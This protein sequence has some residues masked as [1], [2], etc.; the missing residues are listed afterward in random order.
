VAVRVFD[1][2]LP[3]ERERGL[4]A[5]AQSIAAAA[6]VVVPTDTVYGLC[7]DAFSAAAVTSLV[8]AKGTGAAPPVLV[9]SPDALDGLAMEVSSAARSLVEGFWPGGLTLLCRARP[10]LD[11]GLGDGGTVAIRMPLHPLSLELLERTGPLAASGANVA[12][13]SPAVTAAG[14]KEM[15]GDAVE[16]YLDGGPCLDDPPS[17]IVDTTGDRVVVVREGAVPVA[18]LRAVLQGDLAEPAGAAR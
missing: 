10:T 3:P 16:V 11:W 5:A 15:L 17:T 7:A 13:R 14:A 8:Q 2:A 1:C 6:L 4:A 12:G 18:D 9:G